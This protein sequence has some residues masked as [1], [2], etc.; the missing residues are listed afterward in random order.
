M[1]S[2]I[3]KIDRK[4]LVNIQG[5]AP[6]LHKTSLALSGLGE[7]GWAASLLLALPALRGNKKWL[8]A[9]VAPPLAGGL[10]GMAKGVY[11]RTRPFQRDFSPHPTIGRR[12]SSSSLPSGHA[13]SAFAAVAAA[14][15]INPQTL[16]ITL[17]LST[18]TSLSRVH[19][20]VHYPI[21]VI[22]GALLGLWVGYKITKPVHCQ[23]TL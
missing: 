12:P 14:A 7:W 3:R 9:A 19:L 11:P 15:Y 8:L 6:H 18:A 5:R 10:A 2:K 13:A 1:L 21:D 16:I 20:G 23:K 17:P 4:V 22:S